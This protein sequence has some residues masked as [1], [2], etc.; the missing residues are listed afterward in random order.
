MRFLF[1]KKMFGRMA[2]SEQQLKF[3]R[4]LPNAVV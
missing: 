4:N 2:Q 1:F 3:E